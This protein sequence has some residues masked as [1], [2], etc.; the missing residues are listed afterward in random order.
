METVR[1]IVDHNTIRLVTPLALPEGCEIE[2]EPRLVVVASASENTSPTEPLQF[3]EEG[4]R[5]VYAIL[6]ERYDSGFTDTAA[7]HNEHQP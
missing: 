7:R 1:G 3:S 4:L 5:Q 2:F 6:S